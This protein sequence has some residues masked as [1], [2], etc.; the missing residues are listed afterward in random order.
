ML[1][2]APLAV[3]LIAAGDGARLLEL[4]WLRYCGRVSYGWYLWHYALLWPVTLAGRGNHWALGLA[5]SCVALGI[6]SLSYR[7]LEQP[8]IA[9][10][11]RRTTPSA[12]TPAQPRDAAQSGGILGPGTEPQPLAG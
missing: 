8:A 4:P 12:Q 6:A 3:L 9:H 5:L 1:V 7:Y 10:M 11:K 2:A